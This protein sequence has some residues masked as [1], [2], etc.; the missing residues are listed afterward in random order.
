MTLVDTNILIDVL[1]VD[2]AWYRWSLDALDQRATDGALLINDVV[3]AELAVRMHSIAALG[4]ADGLVAIYTNRSLI[5]F[6]VCF[7]S[8]NVKSVLIIF[9]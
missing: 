2:S 4:K 7:N 5:A 8:A 6:A 3:Y 1:M 9:R